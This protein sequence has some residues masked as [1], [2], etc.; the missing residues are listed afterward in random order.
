MQVYLCSEHVLSVSSLF[1]LC[2][3]FL[4]FFLQI[5]SQFGVNIELHYRPK[6]DAF[7]NH[8]RRKLSK[9]FI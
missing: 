1:S 8:F 9:T 4:F 2:S 3:A 7:R 5:V 6:P